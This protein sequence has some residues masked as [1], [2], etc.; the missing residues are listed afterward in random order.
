MSQTVGP[1]IAPCSPSFLGLAVVER[2]LI[3]QQLDFQSLSRVYRCSRQLRGEALHPRAGSS[4]VLGSGSDSFGRPVSRFQQG[5]S[6]YWLDDGIDYRSCTL[7]RAQLPVSLSVL[8]Y[9]AAPPAGPDTVAAITARLSLFSKVHRLELGNM[10]WT[11]AMALQL[12]Q[13]K[14]FST[15]HTVNVVYGGS[16]WVAH[17]LTQR[18]LFSLPSL[19]N[20][21]FE[22]SLDYFAPGILSAASRLRALGLPITSGDFRILLPLCSLPSLQILTLQ[23]VKIRNPKHVCVL[24]LPQLTQLTICDAHYLSHAHARALFSQLPALS[25]LSIV[26]ANASIL[27]LGCG[28]A[29][30]AGL[31]ALRRCRVSGSGVPSVEAV[32]RFLYRFPRLESLVF[33][34]SMQDQAAG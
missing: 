21:T 26:E 11:E 27:L 33:A 4:L 5:L 10:Q 30:Q 25:N 13:H 15:V 23:S 29:G 6:F 2:Q 7:A 8:N 31:P 19:T 14:A 17:S 3:M 24:P 34:F 32:H 28:D 1:A 16:I 20:L 22:C 12:L 9:S 18:A